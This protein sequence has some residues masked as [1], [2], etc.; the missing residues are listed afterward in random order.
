MIVKPLSDNVYAGT[1]KA[2]KAAVDYRDAFL[3]EDDPFGHQIWVR[4]RLL[5]N[6]KS[7]I[8]GVHRYQFIDNPRTGNVRA[9]RLA[10]W[11]DEHGFNCKRKFSV[12][13]Y[14]EREARRL[15]IA[16]REYQLN[17][18]CAINVD[19]RET[20]PPD[21]AQIWEASKAQVRRARRRKGKIRKGNIPLPSEP[22]EDVYEERGGEEG[23]RTVEATIDRYG[24]VRL[25]E[26]VK[27]TG[28]R[29]AIVAIL[30]EAPEHPRSKR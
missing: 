1:R 19:V 29:R 7:G 22:S 6:N 24:N 2:L 10:S 15:A 4:T 25:L 18:V 8:P 28:T 30:A 23:I 13:R 3:T 17:R 27:L 14:G 21:H 9:F 20:E 5:K 12:A 11:I 16:E 26:P